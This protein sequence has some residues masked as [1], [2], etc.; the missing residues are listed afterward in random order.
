MLL[1]CNSDFNIDIKYNELFVGICG[2]LCVKLFSIICIHRCVCVCVNYACSFMT[3]MIAR[4]E[5]VC[6][7]Y[8]MEDLYL[9]VK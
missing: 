2:I 7:Y 9:L 1:K 3:C 4:C 8:I 5:G 6:V